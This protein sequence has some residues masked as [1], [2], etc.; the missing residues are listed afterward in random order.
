M[1]TSAT[2]LENPPAAPRAGLTRRDLLVRA[3]AGGGFM[4]GFAVA[5]AGTSDAQAATTSSA[6]TAWIVIGSDESITLQVPI[7][8]MGQGTMTGLAQVMADELRVAWSKIAVVHAPV[9]AAHGGTNA[10]PWGRFTG[11]SLGIR[12]FAPGIQQAAA[13][14]RQ[15]LITAAAAQ[16]LGGS[17]TAVNGTVTNG[18]ASLTYGSLATAAAQV[19][20]PANTPLNQYP[21]AVVGTSAPRV[22]I[23]AKVTGAAQF[24]IDVFLPGMVFAAV[25]HC[26]TVG[27]T[28]GMVGSKPAG[29]LGVVQVGTRPGQ[30]ANGVAVVAATTWDAMQAVNRLS[31]NWNLPADA[32]SNDSAAIGAR[33][34]WLMA[35]ATPIVAEQSPNVAGLATGLAL[36]NAAIDAT[37]QLPYLAH[38]AME[39][40]NCTVRYTPGSPGTCEV[41]APTQA[42]DGAKATAQAMCPAGTVVKLVNTLAG[43]GFGRKFEMDFIREAV[44]VGLAFPGK[45]VKLTWPRAQDFA[46]DQFRPMAL[47]RVQAAASA[48]TGRITAWRHRIVTPSIAVQRGGSASALDSSA[49]DGAVDLPYALDPCLVEYIRHDS[50]IPVGYW[51]SVGMSINTFAVES[52]IDEL[53]AA[54]GAD[55]IQF[56]LDN[57][58]DPRMV[59]VLSALRTF[60]NWATAPAAGRARG[61]AIAKGFGSWMGQ[62]AEVSVN[63]TTGALTVHRVATVID[64]GTAIN[65]DAIQGQIEGAVAQAMAATLWVQQ[66]FVNGVPQVGNFNKYRPVRLQEMPQVDVKI[67]Q[68]G[69]VGGVGETG[70]PCVA[71]AIASAHARL[72]GAA[73]RKR[74]LPFFPGT[75]LGGL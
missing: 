50:T 75:T 53:A 13:N 49:V 21:R 31:V 40:L 9:D 6:V 1:T 44:Q 8:E 47:S 37:Y 63:A 7:T 24:G 12:L 68:G 15:M 25:K 36:P 4:V 52:A 60:S 61:V 29:A 72:V 57:L 70:V 16:G 56:R 66:T 38:A 20:L 54:I 65:P 59:S 28:V 46:Y 35:N 22:D 42:P 43:G 73:A 64:V 5:G 26:P 32:A 14:A 34:A 3:A 55:P 41:W 27:G 51:R 69:G 48:T 58:S 10:G 23:A 30:P 74:A 62:V 39:P 67:L 2:S 17:L 45:P 18:T 33:A 71:P 19:V 11:G